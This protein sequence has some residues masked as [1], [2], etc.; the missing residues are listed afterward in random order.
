MNRQ[1]KKFT[2]Q[3]EDLTGFDKWEST[4]KK[5]NETLESVKIAEEQQQTENQVTQ[6]EEK[7]KNS[8][9]ENI[10]QN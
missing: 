6:P 8:P 3:D 2:I 4:I 7:V 1:N 10:T 9:V 5:V